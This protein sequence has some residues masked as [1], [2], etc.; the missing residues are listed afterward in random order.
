MTFPSPPRSPRLGALLALAL[1]SGVTT[2]RAQSS[3]ELAWDAPDECPSGES[4]LTRVRS[5]AGESLRGSRLKATGRVEH[6]DGRYRLT[7]T[8]HQGSEV[9]ER[10]MESSSCDDL[11]GAA[12]VALGLLL[13][14]EP[15]AGGATENPEAGT[16]PDAGGGNTANGDAR[17]NADTAAAPGNG[18]SKSERS[19]APSSVAPRNPRAPESETS[20]P[21]AEPDSGS[22]QRRWN[23]V[24]RAPSGTVALGLVSQ[25]MF[26]LGA[27]LGFRYDEWR[28]LA[29]GRVFEAA[30]LTD[31]LSN[32][33]ARV[34]RITADA[35][36][37]REWRTERVEFGPCADVGLSF[38]SMRGK[39]PHVVAQS[40][41]TRVFAFGAGADGRFWLGS[42]VAVFGTAS[43]AVQ[44]SR[45]TPSVTNFGDVVR[46]GAVDFSFALGS[47]WFF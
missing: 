22:G 11:A 9:R 39:G 30:T 25:P 23:V 13:R 40:H 6:R 31:A 36:V 34:G 27:G 35:S 1:M 14:K 46:L 10:T 18:G 41:H 26:A 28:M 16:P 21:T 43:F 32:V 20:S 7:L 33:G 12:A 2:A 44:A 3:L 37:C 29:E 47:E 24:A 19:K 42:W 17:G 8:V 45:P 38:V 15:T 4:V 5:L